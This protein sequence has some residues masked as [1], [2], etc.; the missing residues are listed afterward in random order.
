MRC[1]KHLTDLSSSVGVCAT[2]L[3]ERLLSLIA[4]QAQAQAQAQQAQLARAAAAAVED[5]RKPDPPPLIFP[6]S[7]SPYVSRRKSDDNSATW[8]HHQ[9]FYS[10]PQVGPTYRTATA[11]DFEA[12]RSFKK[13]NRFWL[14]SNLFRSRSEKFNSDPGVH[15][16]RDSCDEPSSSSSSPSWFSAI[17]AV[18]RKKQQSSRTSHVDEFGQF[19]PIDRRSCK[20]ID[21]GMSP[22]IEADSGD[23]YDRSPSGS[24]PEVS[25]RW[26][27]TPTAARRSRTGPRNV[28]GLAFCLSPLV[29]A[30]PNRHWNQKGGL[31]PDMSFTSEGRPPMKP[32]LATAAGFCANRS[33]KLADFGRVKP[34]R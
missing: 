30:S 1:K 21:R 19:R 17:F 26:K 11:T 4:A 10:T 18:R 12:A 14:F 20:I 7:V 23:E 9:R 29:R 15:Y 25:P 33:R 13:K 32:H 27:M 22:A 8:I 34:N 16:H 31:P 5:R 6:R 28:S 24:S 2:C 3:R